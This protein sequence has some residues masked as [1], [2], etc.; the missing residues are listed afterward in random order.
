M[1]TRN[2]TNSS[3]PVSMGSDAKSIIEH[4]KAEF[5]K[6]K[7]EFSEMR[8]KFSEFLTAKF[9]EVDDLKEQ[10]HD[11]NR[12][13]RKLEDTIEDASA[14][15]R[16][17][18]LILGGKC[19]PVSYQGEICSTIVQNLVKEH[20]NLEIQSSDISTA[21]RLGIK[22]QN[23][24][25]DKRNIIVKFCRRD[26]KREVLVASKQKRSSDI[27][28]NESLTP[29]R[30]VLHDTLRNMKRQHPDLIKGCTTID[31]RVYAFTP[32]ISPGPNSRDMR[33][34][35][36]NQDVLKDFCRTYIKRPLDLFLQ[37]VPAVL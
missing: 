10:V 32:P 34:H 3:K 16:R 23:Q 28:A 20:L 27:F 17:D 13:I 8:T 11:L 18:A 29:K 15:E 37:N 5:L 33:H 19:L 1:N 12:T 24:T 2:S 31:G 36:I 4:V 35:I 30:K 7:S 9:K 25:A 21:H 6:M 26:V 22:R 14:Y